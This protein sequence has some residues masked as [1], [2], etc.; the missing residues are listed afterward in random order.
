VGPAASGE[1]QLTAWRLFA[2]TGQSLFSRSESSKPSFIKGDPA[3]NPAVDRMRTAASLS[4]SCTI[5]A[6]RFA[7]VNRNPQYDGIT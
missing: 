3:P 5:V 4:S 1:A 2:G 7:P 6:T